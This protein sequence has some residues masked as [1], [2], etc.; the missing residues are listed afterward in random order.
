MNTRI[1]R[2]IKDR[3]YEDISDFAFDWSMDDSL[4]LEL[5]IEDDVQIDDGDFYYIARGQVTFDECGVYRDVPGYGLERLEAEQPVA[6]DINMTIEL[7]S[8]DDSNRLVET[9]QITD[10]SEIYCL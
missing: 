8:K 7:W 9:L 6:R 5:Y 1:L 3:I 10:L 4:V 2:Q